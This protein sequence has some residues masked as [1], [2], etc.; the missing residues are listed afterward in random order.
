MQCLTTWNIMG[1]EMVMD[2]QF[3]TNWSGVIE[4]E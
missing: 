3:K 2:G 1:K 4:Y